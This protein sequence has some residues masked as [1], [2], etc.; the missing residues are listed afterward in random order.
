VVA[1]LALLAFSVHK[2]RVP[3]EVPD[4]VTGEE[5]DDSGMEGNVEGEGQVVFV[6]EYGMSQGEMDEMA[7]EVGA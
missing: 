2:R 4:D 7:P 6:S 3:A 5:S 1:A